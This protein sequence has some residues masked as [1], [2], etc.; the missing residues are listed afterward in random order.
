MARV[1][2]RRKASTEQKLRKIGDVNEE[3]GSQSLLQT[4][5]EAAECSACSETEQPLEMA[6]AWSSAVQQGKEDPGL[7]SLCGFL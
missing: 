6:A 7:L 1:S 2:C 3:C 5:P 4:L